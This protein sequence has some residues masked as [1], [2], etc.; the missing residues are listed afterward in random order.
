M[1]RLVVLFLLLAVPAHALST[2]EVSPYKQYFPKVKGDAL[3]WDLFETTKEQQKKVTHPE[4]GYSFEVTPI[5]SEQLMVLDGTEVTLTGF[6]FP[7]E[8]AEKQSSFLLGPF[9]P[10]CPFHYHAPPAFIVEVKAAKPLEFSWDT[11]TLKGTLVLAE[12]DPNG[13][14]YF[15]KNAVRIKH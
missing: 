1:R 9:P 4:G 11:I 10:S 3:P 6:M 5:F 12:K 7:L 14:F 2:E 13:V 15:L 8:Q